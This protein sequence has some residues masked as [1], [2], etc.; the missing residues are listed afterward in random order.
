M[1]VSIEQGT[2]MLLN[3]VDDYRNEQNYLVL[4]V[5]L[6]PIIKARSLLRPASPVDRQ[7]IAVNRVR[8]H[9]TMKFLLPSRMRRCRQL[10][11]KKLTIQHHHR[12]R[13]DKLRWC[14]LQR[15]TLRIPSVNPTA[16]FIS[17]FFQTNNLLTSRLVPMETKTHY[18]A[19]FMEKSV[20]PVT[21]Q[22]LKHSQY[23]ST[24]SLCYASLHS[25]L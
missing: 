12:T 23:C 1:V 17:T 6:W 2:H 15:Y 14:L 13:K 7:I 21:V 5:V 20:V 10:A 8:L 25:S 16:L 4:P 3:V 11:L 9:P 24:S 19:E 18:Q 22:Q